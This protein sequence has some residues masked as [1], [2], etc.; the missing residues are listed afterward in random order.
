VEIAK[1]PDNVFL[2]ALDGPGTIGFSR[3]IAAADQKYILE[4]YREYHGPK[5]PSLNHQGIEDGFL[6]KA[7]TIYYFFGHRWRELQGAD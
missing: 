2:Q 7:S 5:P 1:V 3:T 4:H 6:D